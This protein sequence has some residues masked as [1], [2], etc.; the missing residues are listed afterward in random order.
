MLAAHAAVAIESAR[1]NQIAGEMSKTDPLTHLHNRRR[2][3]EDLEAECKRSTR[4]RRP[5][6]FIMLDV[7]NFKACNDTHGHPRADLA[8]QAIAV[9]IG[10]TMRATDSAY[11]YGGEEVCVLLRETNAENAMHFA[12]RLRLGIELRFANG[13]LGLTASFG[14]AEFSETTPGHRTHWSRAADRAMYESEA[15]RQEIASAA[16]RA[17]PEARLR[18]GGPMSQA[19]RSVPGARTDEM[20]TSESVIRGFLEAAPDAVVIVNQAGNIVMVNAQTERLFGYRPLRVGRTGRRTFDARALSR[21]PS[22]A[23]GKTT[24]RIR[25]RPV[26]G[27]W[28]GAL[29][30]SQRS[31]RVSRRNQSRPAEESTRDAHLEHHP[32]YQ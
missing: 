31:K 20:G 13:P 25:K 24:L 29:R 8:L 22:G 3:D 15:R 23:A 30:P 14:V 21:P 19:D 4:Y 16:Q 18:W 12:E 17:S 26:C 32:R 5:L 11:R 7:D 1:L 9:V 2:L 10:D 28:L 6:S 27:F